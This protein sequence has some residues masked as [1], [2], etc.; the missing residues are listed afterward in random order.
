[1]LCLGLTALLL[2]AC[3]R[4]APPFLP[5]QVPTAVV[6]NLAAA[7]ENTTVVLRGDVR[8]PEAA[9][10]APAPSLAGCRVYVAHYGKGPLPCEGCPIPFSRSQDIR[11]RVLEG[12]AFVC[13]LADMPPEGVYY[14]Q[15]GLLGPAD[16][17]GPLSATA[18]LDAPPLS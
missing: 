16:A 5:R 7:W 6:E 3:G 17:V 15:V 12:E 18:R 11:G 9:G 13:R 14:F 1:L 10:G 2:P 4:K 8:W